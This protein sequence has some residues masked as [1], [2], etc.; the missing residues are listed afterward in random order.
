MHRDTSFPRFE[1]LPLTG[2]LGAE[3]RGLD[4]AAARASSPAITCIRLPLGS[5]FA[6]LAAGAVPVLVDPGIGI[7]RVRQ[8][9][10][11]VAPA[12][13]VGPAL[14]RRDPPPPRPSPR[15]IRFTAP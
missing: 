14:A 10:D 9:L 1:L 7:R 13:P 11:D 8:A 2:A 6:L 12:A 4:L 3:V 5:A 15:R